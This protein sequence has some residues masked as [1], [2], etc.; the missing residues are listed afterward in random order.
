M[1]NVLTFHFLKN[2]V[3][4]GLTKSGLIIFQY[5]HFCHQ[6][7][8]LIHTLQVDSMEQQI[9]EMTVTIA[10]FEEKK[11]KLEVDQ[12]AYIDKIFVLR[13]VISDLETQ[14]ETKALN[15]HVLSEKVKVI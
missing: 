13:E 11:Q 3:K 5:S 4:N 9:K 2:L 7:T 8:N 15:E 6:F 10:S 14:I 12:K 1:E